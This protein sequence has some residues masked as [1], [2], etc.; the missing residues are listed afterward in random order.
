MSGSTIVIASNNAGK[1]RE[2]ERVLSPFGYKVAPQSLYNVP[3][4][5]E[6]HLTFIENCIIKA[7][8]AARITGMAVIA[9]DSGICVNALGGAPGV[10]SARYAGEPKSD[11][12]NNAELI[13]ALSNTTQR[14]AYYYCVMVYMRHAEDPQPLIAEGRWHGEIVDDARGTDGFGYDPHFFIHELGKTAA[15]LTPEQKDSLSHRGQ[16]LANLASQLGQFN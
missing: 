9:D 13:A 10:H 15:E 12:R 4:A 2:I 16:A 1:L 14:D 8:H 6:P 11:L 5:D 7:R 3:E